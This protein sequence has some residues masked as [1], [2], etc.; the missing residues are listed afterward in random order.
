MIAFHTD[1]LIPSTGLTSSKP[2]ASGTIISSSSFLARAV[3][4]AFFIGPNSYNVNA[5]ITM[6]IKMK[7]L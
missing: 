5:E 7:M 2:G 1:N 6:K 3:C 4:S